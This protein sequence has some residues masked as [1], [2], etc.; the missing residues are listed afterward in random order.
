MSEW[1]SCCIS[2]DTGRKQSSSDGFKDFNESITQ[3]RT[4]W[5]KATKEECWGPQRPTA[6]GDHYHPKDLWDKGREQCYWSQCELEL[7]KKAHMV[8]AVDT[9]GSSHCQ[10]SV[11]KQRGRQGKDFLIS[12]SSYLPIHCQHLPL[13]NLNRKPKEPGNGLSYSVDQGKKSW[14]WLWMG[15]QRMTRITVC[16][17]AWHI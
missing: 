1:I 15:R 6:A 7:W 9:E 13:A 4:G 3:G 14:R 8:G 10:E 2:Q 11:P 17:M 5:V 12:V 16:I